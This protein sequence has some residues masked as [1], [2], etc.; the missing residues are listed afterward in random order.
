MFTFLMWF[1]VC[2]CIDMYVYIHHMFSVCPCID[3][4]VYIH[5]VFCMSMYRH[6]CL[7]SSCGSLYVHVLDMYVYIHYMFSVCPCI[8]MYVYIHYMF[9][10]CPCIDM[11]VCIPHVVLCMSMYRL[12]CLHSSCG[13][14]YVHV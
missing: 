7:H 13:S 12:V 11:Y 9:S 14:L 3:M 1:S 2:P 5:H 10:V 4:Y 6:V 8:D